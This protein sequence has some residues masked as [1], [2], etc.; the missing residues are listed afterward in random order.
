MPYKIRYAKSAKAE[1]DFLRSTY[2]TDF[3]TDFDAWLQDL[4]NVRNPVPV[5]TSVDAVE[6]F[7]AMVDNSAGT[8]WRK[9]WTKFVQAGALQKLRI[10]L[11]VLRTRC[12]PWEFRITT[13]WFR[14][15]NSISK[16][17]VAYYAI[18]HV[19]RQVIIYLVEMTDAE[20][21]G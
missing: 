7:S 19:E 17:L 9:S 10:L 11:A 18:D 1:V 21:G 4:A 15:L 13:A 14:L 3:G 12:P 20:G 16:E 6:L 8:A 5:R 2:G